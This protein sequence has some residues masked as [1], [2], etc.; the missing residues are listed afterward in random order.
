ML[1]TMLKIF[2]VIFVVTSIIQ[3]A[4]KRTFDNKTLARDKKNI[5]FEVA[6]LTETIKAPKNKSME[7]KI[8]KTPVS[9]LLELM[10]KRGKSPKYEQVGNVS[11]GFFTFRVSVDD[12]SGKS[13][14]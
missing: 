12:D 4:S 10:V 11:D 9:L 1:K 13:Y 5:K 8:L 6:N 2:L 7:G 3:L 14:Q